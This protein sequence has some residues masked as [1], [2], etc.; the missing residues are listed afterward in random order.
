LLRLKL[1]DEQKL[2]ELH[3][4]ARGTAS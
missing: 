1:Y 3:V 2:G 4:E